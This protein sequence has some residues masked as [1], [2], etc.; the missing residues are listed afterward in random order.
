MTERARKMNR[1]GQPPFRGVHSIVSAAVLLASAALGIGASRTLAQQVG[2]RADAIADITTHLPAMHPL[3]KVAPPWR[4]TPMPGGLRLATEIGWPD[5]PEN[6]FV[7]VAERGNGKQRETW[8]GTPVGVKCVDRRAGMMHHYTRRDGLPDDNVAAVVADSDDVWCVT[9]G[10]ETA[11]LCAF[12]APSNRWR[13]VLATPLEGPPVTSYGVPV[14]DEARAIQYA[15][16]PLLATSSHWLAFTSGPVGYG[17]DAV[18][19]LLEKRTGKITDVPWDPAMRADNNLLGTLAL[20]F[21]DDDN[22]LLG[23]NLGL[24]RWNLT[25]KRWHRYLPR[26]IVESLAVL[27]HDT[28]WT[29]GKER[30]SNWYAYDSK[31]PVWTLNRVSL[32]NGQSAEWIPPTTPCRQRDSG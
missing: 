28:V 11:T 8:I 9:T 12:D 14:N 13:T 4:T 6:R 19:H 16:H 17:T 29:V 15:V 5:R 23:T 7:S 26:R 24:L 3:L 32:K 22:V 30:V 2:S 27:D 1:D 21:A 25:E 20:R 31:R 10:K 18:L